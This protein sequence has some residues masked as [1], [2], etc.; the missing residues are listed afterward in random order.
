M[1]KKYSK[2]EMY[3]HSFNELAK[4][5]EYG[6][7]IDIYCS[8]EEECERTIKFINSIVKRMNELF[9]KIQDMSDI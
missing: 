2:Q 7:A 1:E 3:I 9:E 5:L 8:N 4:I 6:N